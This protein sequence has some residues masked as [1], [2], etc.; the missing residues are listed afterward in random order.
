MNVPTLLGTMSHPAQTGIV[1]VD[2]AESVSV[3]FVI[4]HLSGPMNP[5]PAAEPPSNPD[6][7]NITMVYRFCSLPREKAR[8]LLATTSD[9]DKLHELVRALPDEEYKL[10]RVITMKTRS[11]NRATAE[12]IAENIYGTEVEAARVERPKSKDSAPPPAA[13]ASS[14]P[15]KSSEHAENQSS[16]ELLPG[17]FTALEMRPVGWRIEVDPVLE[18]DGR[19]VYLNLAP[20]H[21]EHRGN[22]QGHELLK[23]YPEQPVFSSQKITTAVG[24]Q[25]GSQCFLGTMN[26]PHDT[27]VNG[28][29]D[30][31]RVWFGFVRVTLE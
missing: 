1:E 21:V 14:G 26:A 22:L 11:G 24:A 25:V 31:G 4:P 15:A 10:E 6:S 23:Q 3:T 12:E 2:G 18:R 19:T 5:P 29:T 13:A 8:D 30:D 16:L 7:A 17:R 20:E 9:P 27:G 28:R